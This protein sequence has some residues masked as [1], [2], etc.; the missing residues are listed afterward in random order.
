M[1]KKMIWRLKEQPSTESLREL[2]KD[3]LLTKDEA[4]E[5]LFSSREE[6]ERDVESLQSEIKF[7]RDLVEKLSK[8]QTKTV[9]IIREIEKPYYSR[10]WY[11]PYEFWCSSGGGLYATNFSTGA[12]DTTLTV[13]GTSGAGGAFSSIKTF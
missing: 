1:T 4:R 13:S 7:L 8:S 6:D 11:R 5:I 2:V 3:G 10:P 12:S 9:E